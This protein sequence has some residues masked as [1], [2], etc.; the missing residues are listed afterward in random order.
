MSEHTIAK[1]K[2]PKC[3]VC[4]KRITDLPSNRVIAHAE[5]GEVTYT[6]FCSASCESKYLSKEKE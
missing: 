3:S 6:H 2:A 1:E 5:N 4:S